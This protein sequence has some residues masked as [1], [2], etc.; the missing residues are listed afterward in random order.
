MKFF[1]VFSKIVKIYRFSNVF[2]ME[3][4]NCKIGINGKR[5]S[6]KNFTVIF[7]RF[8]S[9]QISLRQIKKP[10]K[11][12]FDPPQCEAR[13]IDVDEATT[14]KVCVD[15]VSKCPLKSCLCG[16]LVQGYDFRF[17]CER[18]RV[19]IPDGPFL[20]QFDEGRGFLSRSSRLQKNKH[21]HSLDILD[22]FSE[23]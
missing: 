23:P 6:K 22:C 12:F 10:K 3:K 21:P 8:F 14:I 15:C 9:I 1:T 19:Q 16:P 2:S 7:F 17:G 11:V 20:Q 18:S 4:Q 5:Q 13:Y